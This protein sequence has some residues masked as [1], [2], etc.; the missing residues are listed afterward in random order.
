[1]PS[2]RRIQIPRMRR[3]QPSNIHVVFPLQTAASSRIPRTFRR[4][5]ASLHHHFIFLFPFMIHDHIPKRLRTLPPRLDNVFILQIFNCLILSLLW[6][7]ALAELI[8]AIDR[9]T[10]DANITALQKRFLDV[11]VNIKI[12]RTVEGSY[13]RC[14]E[15]SERATHCSSPHGPCEPS[16]RMMDVHEGSSITGFYVTGSSFRARPTLS[17]LSKNTILP[18]EL[19][20]APSSAGYNGSPGLDSQLLPTTQGRQATVRIHISDDRDRRSPGRHGRRAS[21]IIIDTIRPTTSRTGRTLPVPDTDPADEAE[22]ILTLPSPPLHTMHRVAEG[23]RSTLPP[24]ERS[25]T[26]RCDHQAVPEA[27]IVF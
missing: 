26:F 9:L 12:P 3:L 22:L 5:S 1:M 25:S 6:C 17:P 7:R 20:P 16:A 24:P 27:L 15:V 23:D 4:S 10:V 18:L 11:G 13:G 21:L 8:D 2:P 19:A 14:C